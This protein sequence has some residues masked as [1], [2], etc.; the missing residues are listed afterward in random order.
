LLAKNKLG[1]IT[2]TLSYI[3][4]M[5]DL[6]IGL[7]FVAFFKSPIKVPLTYESKDGGCTP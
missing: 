3:K 7:L 1:F 2:P 5:V 4:A 6:K